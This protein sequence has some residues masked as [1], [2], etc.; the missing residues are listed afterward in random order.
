MKP[1]CLSLALCVSALA[2]SNPPKARL[3]EV[4]DI[5]P[6]GYTADLTLDP[7]KDTYSGSISIRMQGNKPVETVWVNQEQLS[8]QSAVLTSQGKEYRGR[9]VPGG[10][11]FVGFTFDGA[12]PAGSA[13]F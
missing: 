7:G 11:D 1:L 2:A 6:T 8:I 9:T 4:E 3:A 5:Q 12:I 10:A 13:V